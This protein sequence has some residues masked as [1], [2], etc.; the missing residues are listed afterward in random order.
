GQRLTAVF[1][2]GR[3]YSNMPLET[4]FPLEVFDE[5]KMEM[6]ETSSSA[7][8]N[9]AVNVNGP[10]G[11]VATTTLRFK[12]KKEIVTFEAEATG[13]SRISARIRR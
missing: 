12:R 3:I 8:N 6:Q 2:E 11:P 13:H 1:H 4:P 5:V 10:C 9:T 7:A